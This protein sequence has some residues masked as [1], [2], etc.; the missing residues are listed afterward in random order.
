[1]ANWIVA[2]VVRA[3]N[4]TKALDYYTRVLGF[5]CPEG[6]IKSVDPD[7]GGIYAVLHRNGA[8]LHLQIRR[9]ESHVAKREH[10]ANDAYFYVDDAAA[11]QA[12]FEERGAWFHRKLV[13]DNPYGLDDF[14]VEDLD[15]NRLTFGSPRR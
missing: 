6:V 4:V 9:Q 11:L 2:P 14:V 3:K 7:E 1:M 10:I 15:G 8:G 13:T 12:E 5:E